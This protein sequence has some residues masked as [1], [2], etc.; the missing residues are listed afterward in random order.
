LPPL[1]ALL[2]RRIGLPTSSR[3]VGLGRPP[4]LGR[5]GA[6]A[7][8]RWGEGGRWLRPGRLAGGAGRLLPPGWPPMGLPTSWGLPPGRLGCSGLR[9]GAGAAAGRAGLEAITTGGL[10]PV[11]GRGWGVL[12]RAGAGAG[13]RLAA[14]RVETGAAGLLAGTGAGRAG[15]G[16][17]GRAGAGAEAAGLAGAAGITAGLAGAG[18]EGG[19]GLAGGAGWAL[20]GGLGA[21]G[22]AGAAGA[23]TAA[24]AAAGGVAAGA[25]FFTVRMALP[26]LAAG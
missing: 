10:A 2:S 8:E 26:W 22:L 20:T 19:A 13:G 5:V 6:G 1:P 21:A 25:A 14:G 11:T 16:V 23:A 7:P 12:G 15:A 9:L 4:W 3:G 17:L 18:R 24:G